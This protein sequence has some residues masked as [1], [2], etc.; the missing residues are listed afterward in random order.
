VAET[1]QVWLKTM[2]EQVTSLFGS[3]PRSHTSIDEGGW[4]SL[5]G[6][7]LADLNMACVFSGPT[8]GTR[9]NEYV[10]AVNRAEVPVI[11]I[12]EEP[13]DELLSEAARLGATH[14]GN[15]PIMLWQ[16]GLIPERTRNGEARI[17]R[18]D[19]ER[20]AAI[21][22]MAE[23]FSLDRAICKVVMSPILESHNVACWIYER[24]HAVVGAGIGIRSGDIV[25]VY[26]MAT[27]EHFQRTGIG[28]TI[29]SSMM[30]NYLD[31]GVASFYRLYA[32]NW[33]ERLR[34][35]VAG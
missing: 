16:D 17:A 6:E 26:S 10:D 7:P 12:L 21:E 25:G 35:V 28:K 29:L 30:S 9:L 8:A 20:T 19:A 27:Q 13:S 32:T 33:G 4:L 5:S 18:D 31:E 2:G 15:I 34:I 3:S 14:V 22:V 11:V 1:G 24:D 23:A